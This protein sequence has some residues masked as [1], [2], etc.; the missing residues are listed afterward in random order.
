MRIPFADL[1][2]RL[3]GARRTSS[4]WLGAGLAL[5]AAV[6]A[7]MTASG[8]ARAQ[9]AA[10]LNTC[11]ACHATLTDRR[12]AAPAAMFSGADVHRERGFACFDCHGGNPTADEKVNAHDTTGRN[13]AMVFRGKPSGQAIIATCARCHSDAE[14]MRTFAPRQRVDQAA[15]YATS[16]HG[17]R[18]ATGDTRVATC[19]SC[20]GAHGVRA[21]SDAKS[22]VFPTNVATTCAAC[23]SNAQHMSAYKQPDG[24]PLPTRQFDDYKQSVHFTALSKSND[25]SAPTC[26]DCHGNHGAVPPGV[27]SM[28][29]V[30]GTCHAVFAQKFD[31][32]VHRQ[33]FDKGCVECHGNHAVLKPS[34]EMLGASG[35]AICA[36]C[37]SG[38][39]DKGAQ[40]AQ[41]MRAQIEHLKADLNRSDALV[42]HVRNAGLEMSEEELAL[43]E[44]RTKLTLARLEMHAAEP[45]LV[46]AVILEGAKIVAAVDGRAQRGVAELQYRR[47]GLA[48]SLGAILLVVIALA[49]KVRQIDRRVPSTAIPLDRRGPD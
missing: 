13:S 26:N 24:T 15:E 9:S 27:G 3:P 46:N 34:D 10:E 42:A 1:S 47:R 44:A 45:A 49:L 7:L 30:C 2:E 11:A 18:L 48:G 17:K 28:A 6:S 21:V 33:I 19:A 25:L 39:D 22:P 20:H 4:T 16:V 40:A 14:L 31:R 8:P 35:Q 12:L 37:H 5:A 29:N 36:T 23:H 41:G 32:S 38:A 43:R